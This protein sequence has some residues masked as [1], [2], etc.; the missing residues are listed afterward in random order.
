MEKDRT[1]KRS[2]ANDLTLWICLAL[3]AVGALTATSAHIVERA[4]S[5]RRM[6]EYI[7]QTV[8]RLAEA[9]ALHIWNLDERAIETYFDAYP[10]NVSLAAVDVR[11]QYGDPLYSRRFFAEPTSLARAAP[12]YWRG[13]RVGVVEATFS[14][15]RLRMSAGSVARI[16]ILGT[17]LG[18]CATVLPVSYLLSIRL[19][20]ALRDVVQQLRAIAGGSFQG[21]LPEHRYKEIDEINHEVNLMVDQIARYT[22]RLHE[23]IGER[24][25]AQE[26]LVR[27]RDELET[28]VE[29]RTAALR[30]ANENLEREH[31]RRR[32]VQAE[33]LDAVTREQQRIAQD[34]HD[35]LCQQLAGIAF[36]CSSAERS[37]RG[38]DEAHAAQIAQ[39][40][41]QIRNAVGET[42]SIAKGLSPVD[43]SEDGLMHAL[44]DFADEV[45]RVYRIAC[46]FSTAGESH[47]QW[48]MGAV[49][50][51]HIAREAVHNA[52]RHGGA[53]EITLRLTVGEERGALVIVD[54]GVGFD[55][56]LVDGDGMGLQG[57]RYRAED[58]GGVFDIISRPGDGTTVSVSFVNRAARPDSPPEGAIAPVPG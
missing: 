19:G 18:I 45:T 20:G 10:P 15:Q 13:E 28:R 34:L 6:R 55:P 5:G 7:D 50:L 22:H 42:R 25:T 49:Q 38:C 24:R 29:A 37:L 30:E 58:I 31:L 16:A 26:A 2:M 52:I 17:L 14:T 48:D 23:E 53:T 12:V 27:I 1:R 3:V 57:M 51:F 4:L 36:M 40:G 32:R 44:R 8:E 47:L 54:N 33:M 43:V 41:T 39:I 56:D 9:L 35:T 21:H 46:R 11:T